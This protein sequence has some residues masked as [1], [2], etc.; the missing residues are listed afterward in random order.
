MFPNMDVMDAALGR[1]HS[2]LMHLGTSNGVEKVSDSEID[3][4]RMGTLF[5]SERSV[6]GRAPNEY[7]ALCK[8]CGSMAMGVYEEASIEVKIKMYANTLSKFLYAMAAYL[9][10]V[11]NGPIGIDN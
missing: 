11:Y 5:F 2:M 7:G 9:N 10:T 8:V 4:L 6:S 3:Y 1:I